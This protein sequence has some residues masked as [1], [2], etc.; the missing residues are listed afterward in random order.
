MSKNDDTEEKSLPPSRVKLDRLRREGQVARSKEIP[1]AMSLLAIAAYLAC[2]LGN[3]LRDFARIF[4]IG[5]DAAGLTGSQR[6]QPGFPLTAVKDMAEILFGILWM[7]M[8]LGLSIAIAVSILDGQG[9]PVTTKHMNFDLNRLNPVSGIKKLFSVTNLV[10]FLKGIVKVIILSFAGGGAILYFL[11]GIFWAPLCGEACSLSVAAYLIGTIVVIAAAIMLAAA[12]FDL[13]IS[14]LLFRRE[15]RM[16]KT[17]ARREHKDTQGDPHLKSAR[18]RV[19]AEMRNA[20]PR[21]E[22]PEKRLDGTL[23][24]SAD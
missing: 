8:L 7:P 14:R 23:K 9:F 15:H 21:K 18:R 24:L 3:I 20:P 5:F 1:V 6:T 11:N 4:G 13:S 10:E 19:G 12:F 16:T 22:K 2:A 17:E